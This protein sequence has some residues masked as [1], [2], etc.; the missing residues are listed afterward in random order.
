LLGAYN[1]VMRGIVVVLGLLVACGGKAAPPA[2]ADASPQLDAPAA[3]AAT[4]CAVEGAPGQ[5]LDTGVCA[6]MPD[7]TAFPGYCPG[8]SSIQCCIQTP[9]VANNPPTPTGY[10]LMQQ[11]DVTPEMTAWAVMIL[12]DPVTYPMFATATMQ[13]G[14]LSVLARVEWHPPDFQSSAVHR[15][16]TLYEPI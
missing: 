16:V 2:T 5:C 14:T 8:S 12:N 11:A 6:A 1:E 9:S 10:Q 15:G 3:D 13:F 4:S 7:H